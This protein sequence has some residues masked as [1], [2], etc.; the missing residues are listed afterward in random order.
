VDTV[1]VDAVECSNCGRLKNMIWFK[2]SIHAVWSG[3]GFRMSKTRSKQI[4]VERKL[5]LLTHFVPRN[6]SSGVLHDSSEI[7]P[8]VRD[9]PSGP[10]TQR[11][12]RLAR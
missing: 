6:V 3:V 7:L 10:T 12:R 2:F 8:P 11:C 1:D 4:S 5:T 9:K